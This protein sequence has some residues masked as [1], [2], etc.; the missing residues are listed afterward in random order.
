MLNFKSYIQLTEE[1]S[2]SEKAVVDEW[3]VDSKAHNYSD[4][5]FNGSLPEHHTRSFAFNHTL[6]DSVHSHLT[7]KGIDTSKADLINGTVKDKYGRDTKIGKHITD[8]KVLNDYAT[9]RK[10]ASGKQMHI[11]I[12]RQRHAVAGITSGSQCWKDGSCMNFNTGANKHYLQSDVKHGSMVA[13]LKDD[14]GKEHARISIKPHHDN[15]GNTIGVPE[16]RTWGEVGHDFHAQVSSIIHNH[17]NKNAPDGVYAKDHR[18]YDDSDKPRHYLV[19]DIDKAQNS[20]DTE[21]RLAAIHHPDVTVKHL[22]K[23]INDRDWTVREAAARHPKATAEHIT[24]ALNDPVNIYV[25]RAAIKNPNANA[26]HITTA[27]KD[28]NSEIR[29]LAAQHPNANADHITTALSDSE[30]DVRRLAIWHPSANAEHITK[31]LND[32]DWLTRRAAI[33]NPL[34]NVDHITKALKDVDS[35]VRIAALNHPKVTAEHINTAL[36][37]ENVDVQRAA[38]KL[39]KSA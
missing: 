39:Q 5:F 24:K 36:N 2:D 17:L 16:D 18:L 27:L 11:E 1:L 7:S 31:A 12:S 28:R 37:D 29:Q 4:H 34:S 23:A 30:R 38:A 8:T 25:R 9:A 20:D 21:V 13:Y 35:K 26:G 32:T 19:R 22:D 3:P 10:S 6:P 33:Q 14:H 15:Q